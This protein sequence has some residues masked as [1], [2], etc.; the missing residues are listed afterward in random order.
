MLKQTGLDQNPPV[1]VLLVDDHRVVR[2]G[3]RTLLSDCPAVGVVAEAGTGREALAETANSRPDVVL[4]DIRLP[5]GSGI[6]A[7]R[8]IKEIS[9]TTRVLVLTSYVDDATVLSAIEAGADG[10]LLKEADGPDLAEAVVHV[11]RGGAML[12]PFVARRVLDQ[13]RAE[14]NS[15]QAPLTA[16]EQRLLE[17]VSQG[18]TNKEIAG[19]LGLGE[20][21]VR[22]YLSQLYQRLRVANRAQAVAT[23]HQ[24]RSKP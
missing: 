19:D 24:L 7:T 10:Y 8:R 15:G 14:K 17:L 9:P 4:M 11:A 2:V 1:R 12:D 18:R 5:D 3:I 20:G 16:Q 6:E 13:R 23:L 22:N 21:T